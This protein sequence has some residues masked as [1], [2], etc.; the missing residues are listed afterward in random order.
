MRKIISNLWVQL[1]LSLITAL[2]GTAVFSWLAIIFWI[3]YAGFSFFDIGSS[4]DNSPITYAAALAYT[5]LIFAFPVLVWLRFNK[6][7]R[8]K[9]AGKKLRTF[10]FLVFATLPFLAYFGWAAFSS[11]QTIYKNYQS[12]RKACAVENGVNRITSGG[13]TYEFECKN[14]ILNGLKKT[15]NTNGTLIYQ[16]NYLNGKL[17]GVEYTYHDDGTL[18]VLTNYTNNKRTGEEIYFNGN[19]STS[20]YII[21]QNA[22]PKQVYFQIPEKTIDGELDLKGQNYFCKNREEFLSKN[23]SFSCTNN[24]VNGDFIR[25]DSKGNLSLKVYMVNGVLNGAY[26]QFLDGKLS[27]HMEFKNGILDGKVYTHFSDGK[28]EYEGQYTSGLQNGVFRRYDYLGN[29]ISEVVFNEGKITK[30]NIN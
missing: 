17:D 27:L 7:E 21:N 3:K 14:G 28:L 13:E 5:I 19:G 8:L 6:S 1:I 29:I 24:I 10:T 15:Y 2:L 25:L 26:E 22:K 9:K 12:V 4:G 30:I 11:L 18:Y 20:L 23:Y 16:A